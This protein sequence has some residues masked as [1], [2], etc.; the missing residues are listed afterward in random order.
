[1]KRIC[2]MIKSFFIWWWFPLFLWPYC[3]IHGWYCMVKLDVSHS[4]KGC[5]LIY[6]KMI[7]INRW[8]TDYFVLEGGGRAASFL[9]L[10]FIV[11]VFF[12]S[13]SLICP[14]LCCDFTWVGTFFCYPITIAQTPPFSGLHWS[15]K[16]VMGTA[17]PFKIYTAQWKW[18]E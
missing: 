16:S 7:H 1:M 14:I 10:Y 18:Y 4:V 3:V 13:W 11:M 17:A 12:F 8:W 6:T 9:S 5:S 2:L 15:H